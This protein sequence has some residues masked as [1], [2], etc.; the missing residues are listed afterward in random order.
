MANDHRDG[1]RTGMLL[2]FGNTK[3]DER[4]A[5]KMHRVLER[6]W[7]SAPNGYRGTAPLQLDSCEWWW[8]LSTVLADFEADTITADTTAI[9]NPYTITKRRSWMLHWIFHANCSI[10]QWFWK[11]LCLRVQRGLFV[12]GNW[13]SI[14]LWATNGSAIC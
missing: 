7:V 1:A 11:C 6:G 3:S 12:D 2:H 13:W 4:M 8:R 9:T 10:L 14:G 5:P